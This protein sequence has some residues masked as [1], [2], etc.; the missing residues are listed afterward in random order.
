MK[1][2]RFFW[3]MLIPFIFVLLIV[4][5]VGSVFIVNKFDKDYLADK[6]QELTRMADLVVISY[7]LFAKN[8]KLSEL[9]AIFRKFALEEGVDISVITTA[10]DTVFDSSNVKNVLDNYDRKEDLRS[11]L[12]GVPA[13]DLHFSEIFSLHVFSVAQPILIDNMVVGAVQV[14]C[15]LKKMDERNNAFI[16]EMIKIGLI[17]ILSGGV[18]SYLFSRSI[19]LSLERMRQGA[20]RLGRNE[21]GRKIE[22]SNITEVSR[23]IQALN[24]LSYEV[25]E[26]ISALDKERTE[27]NL[28]LESMTEGVIALNN[29]AYIMYANT[30]A[31]RIFDTKDSIKSGSLL[32][33]NIR[34]PTVCRIVDDCLEGKGQQQ[35]LMLELMPSEK[36]VLMKV[37]FLKDAAGL[38]LVFHDIT[39]VLRLERTRQDFVANVS[40]ELRTPITSIVGFVETLI[41][42]A[43]EDEQS[44]KRFLSI[45]AEQSKRMAQIIDDLL[46]LSRLDSGKEMAKERLP[47]GMIISGSIALTSEYFIKKNVKVNY[48][49]KGDAEVFCHPHLLEQA[50]INLLTNAARYSEKNSQIWIEVDFTT[51]F[52]HIS[53]KDRGI[54]IAVEFQERIFERFYRTDKARSRAEGGTGLGLSIVKHIAMLH[55]GRVEL[56]SEVGVGSTFTLCIPYNN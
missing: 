48:S 3:V 15:Q 8:K 47:L 55:G 28:V 32:H 11:A 21:Y 38:L 33:A 2:K 17:A 7:Q 43:V 9:D 49:Y 24:H 4:G 39:Q 35:E 5:V 45:I 6:K 18:I 20:E 1:T 37:V 31:E 50:I 19:S 44:A 22:D 51:T 23:T 52:V 27:K 54:G 34:V 36:N 40:H 10:G 12:Y 53:V 30:A 41:D 56:E 13:S 16:F 42:G 29:E 26:R 14:R 46:I 25:Y